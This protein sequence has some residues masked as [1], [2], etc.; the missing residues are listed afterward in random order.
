MPV[1]SVEL[2]AAAKLIAERDEIRTSHA[3]SGGHDDGIRNSSASADG[4][5][6]V[7]GA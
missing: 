2:D 6:R 7:T 1:E 3:I 5:P 4:T